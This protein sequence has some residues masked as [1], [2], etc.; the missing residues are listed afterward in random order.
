MSLEAA[1]GLQQGHARPR[2][3]ARRS[4]SS[5]VVV[6]LGPNAAGK[7]TLLRALAGLVPLERGRVVARRRG[8]RGPGGRRARADRAAPVGVVFQD[9]LLFPHMTALE[10]VAFGLRSR[11]AEP[12]RA[13]ERALALL[14]RVGLADLRRGEAPGA[15]GR[16]GAARR[17]GAGARHRPAPA[18][19]R[20]AARGHGRRRARRAAPR[21][22][23]APR[24]VTRAPAW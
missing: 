4:R 6:L 11:G 18:A 23:P 1:V 21:P 2:R 22:L 19:A 3:R 12:R 17:A 15:L 14:D 5:G 20:R 10:N 7:T 16:P 8:P 13:R 9:Y 24:R